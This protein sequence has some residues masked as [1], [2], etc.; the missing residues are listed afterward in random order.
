MK[1]TT[2]APIAALAIASIVFAQ[3]EACQTC[4]Q[5]SLKALPLCAGVNVTLGEFDPNSKPEYAACLCQSTSG[6]WIDS[7]IASKTCSDDILSFKASYAESLTGMGLNCNGTTP[8][9]IPAP[10]A[11]VA[12]SS[13]LPSGGSP[14]SG[15]AGA[16]KPTGANAG[17]VNGPSFLLAETMGVLAVVA[18]IGANFL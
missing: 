16:A 7:C 6:S 2:L 14:T 1:F 3:N 12:P 10:S 15:G 9:F 8:T 11:S 17:N 4:L 13:A 5:T 18:A